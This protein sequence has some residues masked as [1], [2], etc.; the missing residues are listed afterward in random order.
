MRRHSVNVRIGIG[1]DFHRFVAGRPLVLG[2]VPIPHTQGLLGHS[3]ADVLTH[4][5]C[6]AL[7]GAAGLG[8][9][10]THFPDS[11]PRYRD[12]SSLHLLKTVMALLA[13]EQYC[14][15][16]IDCVIIAQEPGLA[17]HFSTMKE[18]LSPILNLAQTQI[19]LKATTSEQMGPIGQGEGIAALAVCLI[20]KA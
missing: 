9:I 6:D 7:L 18:T 12:I 16:N 20:G 14:P 1:V 19:G 2:G 4:A 15:V 5:L 3:D 17:P 11:D 13:E 10:G 8:D